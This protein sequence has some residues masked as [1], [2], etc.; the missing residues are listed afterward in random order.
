MFRRSFRSLAA[1]VM[2]AACALAASAPVQMARTAVV[3]PFMA[4]A[5][6]VN[7]ATWAHPAPTQSV[8]FRL[9]RLAFYA[10]GSQLL[11]LREWAYPRVLAHAFRFG[12]IRYMAFPGTV[13]ADIGFG[14]VGELAFDGPCRSQP[15]RINHGTPADIVVGRWFTLAADGTARPG[16]T[17]AIGGLFMNPKNQASLGTAAGGTL[18]QTLTVPTGA[19]GEFGYMGAFI[20]QLGAAVAIG[21]AAWYD[22]T[23]GAIGSGAPG[24]GQAAIP[25]SK[26]IRYANA[27]A[28]LAVLELTN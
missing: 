8:A 19:I 5:D 23:T 26:F 22:T 16:G 24:A 6:F 12:I 10:L 28:G 25:N 9:G 20:V 4:F 21:A 11:A 17:G 13:T 14:I 27:A 2:M 18:A 15:A 3:A 1:V 7:G